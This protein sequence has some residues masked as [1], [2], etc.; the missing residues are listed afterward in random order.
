MVLH[1]ASFGPKSGLLK[2][3]TFGRVKAGHVKTAAVRLGS[4]ASVHNESRA[5][6]VGF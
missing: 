5:E 4:L 3:I 6:Q 2:R 1:S